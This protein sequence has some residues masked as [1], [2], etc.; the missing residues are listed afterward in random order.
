MSRRKHIFLF[1]FPPH[2]IYFFFFNYLFYY[3]ISTITQKYY[4]YIYIHVC[5][6]IIH[7]SLYQYYF[8]YIMKTTSTIFNFTISLIYIFSYI[9]LHIHVIRLQFKPWYS[10]L[11]LSWNHSQKSM[12]DLILF[13]SLILLLYPQRYHPYIFSYFN[14][15][16]APLFYIILLNE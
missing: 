6:C 11:Y 9:M 13:P 1:C 15:F 2:M 4:K 5:L 8:F 10:S 7:I 3:F 14:I 12:P 16:L